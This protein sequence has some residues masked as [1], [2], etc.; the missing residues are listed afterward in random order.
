MVTTTTR[1][2]GSPSKYIQ[3]PGE[4]NNLEMYTS[5]YGKKAFYIIDGFLFEGINKRLEGI[6]AGTESTYEAE[7]FTGE[8]SYN[9][10]NRVMELAKKAGADC[11]VA[12][13]G[14]K[15]LDTGKMV[16]MTMDLPIIICPTSASTD[17]PN[18]AMSVIYTDDHE[19]IG[20]V[21]H[22]RNADLVL[23]DS[24]IVAKAP[25]RMFKA[26]MADAMST[27]YE[28]LANEKADGVNYVGKGYRRTKATVALAKLVKELLLADGEKALRAV[29]KGIVT[30]AVENIIECNILLG[31]QF[32]NGG[33]S[34]A[35][36]VHGALTGLPETGKT[37]HGEKVAYGIVVQLCLENAPQKE[38]EQIVN[39]LISIDEPVTLAQLG[40]EESEEN[41]NFLAERISGEKSRAHVEPFLVTFDTVKA[42]LIMANETGRYYLQRAGKL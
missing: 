15:T 27:Y 16:A 8:V 4:Y 30:D 20:C 28:V 31:G 5:V 21:F 42:A 17:A 10:I 2:W 24:E 32:E 38:L 6:Y 26:G 14:G 40:A 19:Y 33:S 7:G 11:V 39:W 3:G 25:I 29:S 34:V 41:I 18:S 13:G 9:E 36:A 23:V 22:K 1:A 37:M 35:H 12:V